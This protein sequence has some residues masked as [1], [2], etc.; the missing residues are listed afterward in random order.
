MEI[1]RRKERLAKF[2]LDAATSDSGSGILDSW[3]CRSGSLRVRKA[4][5]G[6]EEITAK[7]NTTN[8][9]TAVAA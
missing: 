2:S 7:V 9:T 6:E 8:A 3:S 1:Q 5:V 4:K